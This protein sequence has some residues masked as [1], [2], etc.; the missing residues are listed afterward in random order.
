MTGTSK[1]PDDGVT[2]DADVVDAEVVDPDV[3]D[4]EVVDPAGNSGVDDAPEGGV[5]PED[6]VP[7]VGDVAEVI[8]V[9]DDPVAAAQAERDEYLDALRR[10]QAEFENYRKRVSKQQVEQVARAAVSLVDKLLPVLD[11]LDLAAEH[12]GDADSEEGKALVQA[13]ALLNDVLAKEGLERVDPVGDL[14]DPNSHEAVGNV[15]ADENESDEQGP[16]VAQVMRP[17]YRWRGTVVRPAMVLV[18]S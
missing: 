12:L 15:P 7:E 16:T 11:V 1:T 4:A 13:S 3:F 9:D 2:E 5:G 8:V 17:G 18:R 14:F 6:D 10:L